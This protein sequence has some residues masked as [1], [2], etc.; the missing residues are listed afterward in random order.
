VQARI[1]PSDWCR[2][3]E[4]QLKGTSIEWYT[5][6]KVI[7]LS[8]EEFRV[9]FLENYNNSEIQSQLCADIVSP[10]QTPRQSLTEFVLVKN[11]Q[12]R[13]V[14]TG[15]SESD[16]VGIIA[17]LTRDTFRT[18]IRLQWPLTF[19]ELQRIAGVLDPVTDKTNPPPQQWSP[20]PKKGVDTP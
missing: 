12:A 6:I 1:H 14:N 15:L 10:R 18:H 8:W 16:L 3:V 2:A 19:S 7:D 20:K 5:S 4:P 9:E 17:R 11:K 13:R